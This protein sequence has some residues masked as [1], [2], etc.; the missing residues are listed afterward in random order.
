MLLVFLIWM[1]LAYD[2]FCVTTPDFFD[3]NMS[4][5][6]LFNELLYL[7]WETSFVIGVVWETFTRLYLQ[8][9]GIDERLVYRGGLRYP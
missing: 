2:I 5:W 3:Y 9:A 4:F 7:I 1:F 8:G 6:N